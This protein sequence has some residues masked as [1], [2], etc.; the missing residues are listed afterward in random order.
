MDAGDIPWSI[1]DGDAETEGGVDAGG[2]KGR[3]MDISGADCW[4]SD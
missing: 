1:C 2:G 3:V 4:I